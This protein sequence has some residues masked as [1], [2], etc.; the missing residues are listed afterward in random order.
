[1]IFLQISDS[2]ETIERFFTSDGSNLL[3]L[4]LGSMAVAV[5]VLSSAVGLL[6]YKHNKQAERQSEQLQVQYEKYIEQL[7]ELNVD[8]VGTLKDLSNNL[9]ALKD[10]GINMN[11][12]L[13]TTIDHTREHIALKIES[14]KENINKTI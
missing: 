13:K 7:V 1:M 11:E 4:L 10:A 2:T 14:I 8:C 12:E 5:S 9:I 3:G 6:W